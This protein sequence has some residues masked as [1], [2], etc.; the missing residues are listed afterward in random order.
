MRKFLLI[1]MALLVAMTV[2]AKP[3]QNEELDLRI[4]TYNIWAHYARKGK[5]RKGQA[6]ASRSWDNSKKAVAELIVKLDCDLMGMQEVSSVCNEDL[7]QLLKKVGGKK[8]GIWWLNTYPEG[9]KRKV[10]NAILYNKKKFTLAK[11]NLYYF[12]PT[13]EVRSTGWD[14]VYS[15]SVTYRGYSQE[16]WQKVLLYRYP[17]PIGRYR[18]QPRRTTPYRVRPKVQYRRS[19]NYRSGRY[20]CPSR[21][22]IP[23]KYD[24]IL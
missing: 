16:E 18:L 17:R 11:Q 7:T 12:S 24:Q 23:P 4:G 20:E 9:H 13:P 1:M 22:W 14:E 10:G 2:D 19:A 21:R 15:R 8:Y 3:K 6:D 5:I